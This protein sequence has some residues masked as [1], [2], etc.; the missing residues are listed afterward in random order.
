[1]LFY[2]QIVSGLP[3]N[4]QALYGVPKFSFKFSWRAFNPECKID[5]PVLD[6]FFGYTKMPSFFLP[7]A[8]FSTRNPLKSLKKS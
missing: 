2:S 6:K 5:Q 3:P 7:F 8:S 4:S 1:M